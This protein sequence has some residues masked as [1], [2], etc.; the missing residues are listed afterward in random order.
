MV[1]T[2]QDISERKLAEE[3]LRLSASVF[4][5]S[6]DA[7]MITDSTNHIVD[8][9]P[10]SPA[11]PATVAKKRSAASLRCSTQVATSTSSTPRAAQ[12]ERAWP[13]ARRGGTAARTV[14]FSLNLSITCV[15]DEHGQLIHHVAVFSDISRL[16]AHADELDRIAHF[17][18]L[19]G[20][21][22]RRLLDDRLKHAIARAERSGQTLAVCMLDLDGFKP[23]NDQ[24]GHE[25]GDHLLVQIVSRL[26]SMLRKG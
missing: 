22:N 1:G 21:P 26:Q 24:F 15:K 18:P 19:T 13:L 14:R 20:V 11:L 6:Y 17:D 3:M 10:P 5:N 7:I 12:P 25:A 2:H 9:N 16:K 4:T 8:V 23:I